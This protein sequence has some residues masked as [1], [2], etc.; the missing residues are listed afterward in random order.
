MI[1]KNS[2]TR[3]K[4]MFANG[5][6]FMLLLIP[7]QQSTPE[8]HS[9]HQS[10]DQQKMCRIGPLFS[11]ATDDKHAFHYNSCSDCL[12]VNNMPFVSDNIL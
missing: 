11:F 2:V 4:T 10:T 1:Q 12:I 8:C 3:Q 6:S 9:N 7:A 5:L